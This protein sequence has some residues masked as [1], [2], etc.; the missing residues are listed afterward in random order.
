MDEDH[1]DP[2]NVSDSSASS[3]G[4]GAHMKAMVANREYRTAVFG[5]RLAGPDKFQIAKKTIRPKKFSYPYPTNFSNK[6]EALDELDAPQVQA[7]TAL[8]S[9]ANKVSMRKS[10]KRD[11]VQKPR[12]AEKTCLN[13]AELDEYPKSNPTIIAAL[14][15]EPKAIAK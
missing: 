15:D 11:R 4:S 12:C 13:E 1:E 5:C 2:G 10:I 9:W 6:Y 8:S 7:V 14:P 3:C